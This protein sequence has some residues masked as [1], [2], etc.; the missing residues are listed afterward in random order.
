MTK[1]L[2]DTNMRRTCRGFGWSKIGFFTCHMWLHTETSLTASWGKLRDL[3]MWLMRCA[4]SSFS[5][6]F[7]SIYVGN[8]LCEMGKHLRERKTH[9]KLLKVCWN[10]VVF[11]HIYKGE[12][13]FFF[14]LFFFIL[15]CLPSKSVPVLHMHPKY[16]TSPKRLSK[17]TEKLQTWGGKLEQQLG[18]VSLCHSEAGRWFLRITQSIADDW[19]ERRTIPASS[20]VHCL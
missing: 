10:F 5:N 4:P 15:Y 16:I 3:R 9:L 7:G 18:D 8:C 1:T 2:M 14:I 19:K 13:S 17:L 12:S 11:Q 20:F 6:V